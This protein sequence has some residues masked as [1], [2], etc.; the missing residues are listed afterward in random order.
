MAREDR[1]AH[2]QQE[3]VG[4]NDPL[5]LQMQA[6]ATHANPVFEPGEDE[7]VEND[8]AQPCECDLQGLVVKDGNTHKRQREQDEVDGDAE[9]ENG[10]LCD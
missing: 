10:N 6:E 5:M 3:Q 2:Q 9:N 8:R 4:E 1:E 7:L